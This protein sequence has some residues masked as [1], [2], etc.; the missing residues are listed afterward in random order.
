MRARSPHE[1]CQRVPCAGHHLLS[2][3]PA[4][5]PRVIAPADVC[6]TC[7]DF[8]RGLLVP[9]PQCGQAAAHSRALY[10]YIEGRS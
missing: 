5:E 9:V 10:D 3:R 1:V 6:C 8:S 4:G 7:S 2:Y